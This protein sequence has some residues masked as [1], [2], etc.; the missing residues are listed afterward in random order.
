M[1]DGFE[2]LD[3]GKGSPSSSSRPTSSAVHRFRAPHRWIEECGGRSGKGRFLGGRSGITLLELLFSAAGAGY[4]IYGKKQRATVPFVCGLVLMVY[5][6][7]V[8]SNLLLVI[9]GIVLMTCLISSG[10]RSSTGARLTPDASHL[11]RSCVILPPCA[12]WAFI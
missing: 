12:F 2:G 11:R 9:I 4:F 5:P 10:C 7:F 8:S 3:V 6:Y 1:V